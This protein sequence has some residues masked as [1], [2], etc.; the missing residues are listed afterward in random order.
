[1]LDQASANAG[2]NECSISKRGVLVVPMDTGATGQTADLTVADSFGE[3]AFRDCRGLLMQPP[4]QLESPEWQLHA[5]YEYG[6][7]GGI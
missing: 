4:I 6:G 2:M 5:S 3:A 1:V 7:E